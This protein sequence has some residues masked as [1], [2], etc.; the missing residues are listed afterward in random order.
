MPRLGSK[1]SKSLDDRWAKYDQY[2]EASVNGGLTMDINP[3]AVNRDATAAAWI[4]YVD[5]QILN[6]D[7]T[8]ATWL[9]KDY[10]TTLSIGD[11][12]VAGTASIV[13]TTLSIVA[14]VARVAVSGDAA[15]WLAAETDTLT[16][17]NI[18]DPFGN[19]VT[20]GTSVQTFV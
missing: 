20:G 3:T 9:T 16:V 19:T 1:S 4:R 13:S 2:I 18:T 12:S 5:I 11:T 8:I 7:G 15:A 6:S 17:A 10:A 14:G